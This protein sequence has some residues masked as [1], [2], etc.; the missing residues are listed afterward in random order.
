MTLSKLNLTNQFG[1]TSEN[2]VIS[3]DAAYP[4]AAV[5]AVAAESTAG[6]VTIALSTSNTYT[7][8]A[9]NAAVNTALASVVSELNTAITKIN[10]LLT[11]L[12]S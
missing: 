7:D 4:V 3:G 2:Y 5:T 8:A 11:A 9:V 12:K 10:E 1:E 6:A